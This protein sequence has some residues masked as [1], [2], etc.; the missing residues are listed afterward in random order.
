[1]YLVNTG[2]TGGSYGKGGTRFSIPTTRTIVNAILS[3][4]V[5]AAEKDTLPGFNLQ[6]P[7]K[8]AAVDTK[9][10]NPKNTW[11]DTQD[12]DKQSKILMGKFVKNFA[13]FD[14]SPLIRDAG[15]LL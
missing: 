12:Y 3:G 10:L 8:L 13:K 5:G 4:E 6:I 9:L 14:V 7:K 1:V 2:W 15:P 11:Q